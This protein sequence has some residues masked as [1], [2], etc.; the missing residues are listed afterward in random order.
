MQTPQYPVLVVTGALRGADGRWLLQRRPQTGSLARHWE[1]PGGKVDPGEDPPAAL[2]RELAE[3]LGIEVAIEALS[4]VAFATGH[5]GADEYPG[6]ALIL[7]LYRVYG[8]RGDPTALHADAL[9][10]YAADAMAQ[11]KMP[12]ADYPLIASLSRERP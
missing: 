7:L 2:V 9:D 4:P 3:E 8:W 10:W 6:R 12:P 1:F 11:L 5:A